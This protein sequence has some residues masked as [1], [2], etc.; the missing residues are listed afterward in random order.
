MKFKASLLA[1]LLSF[2][3][4]MPLRIYLCL[5][6]IDQETGFYLRG[7][8][9]GLIFN[10][11]WLVAVL[12]LAIL[13]HIGR[14]ESRHPVPAGNKLTG[15]LGLLL[16]FLMIV[17]NVSS[18]FGDLGGY[19]DTPGNMQALL[20][21]A[22][23]IL[24]FISGLALVFYGMLTLFDRPVTGMVAPLMM[25]P[26]V[27]C[28][29][30][31]MYY[32]LSFTSIVT[33]SNRLLLIVFLAVAAMF[34]LG[35]ARVVTKVGSSRGRKGAVAYGFGMGLTGLI[36]TVSRALA[37]LVGRD[38]AYDPFSMENLLFFALA[39]YG[40]VF[41]L[42]L[43]QQYYRSLSSRSRQRTQA[44]RDWDGVEEMDD[45]L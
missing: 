33:I 24:G 44:P 40:A 8:P 3:M 29:L 28:V 2:L 43:V 5:S 20:S 34:F 9:L 10:I 36:Y 23:G 15:A 37:S 6:S 26:A 35:H 27:W 21:A 41:A 45:L 22:A 19:L 32:F 1:F 13:P 12:A 16:G 39:L 4:L 25:L 18:G 30:R 7:H 14:E 11:I 17:D 42:S 31:L 38:G